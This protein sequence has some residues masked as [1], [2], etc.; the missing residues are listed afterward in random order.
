MTHNQTG[1]NLSTLLTVTRS[2]VIS[3]LAIFFLFFFLRKYIS[4]VINILFFLSSY[5]RRKRC[6]KSIKIGT[7]FA[8]YATQKTGH[9]NSYFNNFFSN[10]SLYQRYKKS[11]KP[12]LPMRNVRHVWFFVTVEFPTR[13][14]SVTFWGRCFCSE[15]KLITI[16]KKVHL[17]HSIEWKMQ[18]KNNMQTT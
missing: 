15:I 13:L 7:G 8:I 3:I 12:T 17:Q 18:K 11:E 16:N 1:Y 4:Q 9:V 14:L 10:G 2:T 5:F 6:I